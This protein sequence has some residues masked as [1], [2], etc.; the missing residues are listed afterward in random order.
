VAVA[1]QR[2]QRRRPP[3][4]PGYPAQV[5]IAPRTLLTFILLSATVLAVGGLAYVF[6]TILVQ[7]LVATVLAM[8]LEPLVQV[9]ERRGIRRGGAIAI[10]FALVAVAL[11]GFAYLV[12]EPLVAELNRFANDLPD[13]L[14]ELTHGRG[15]LGFLETRYHV[16]EEAR[17]AVKQH[18]AEGATGT[19]S[20]VTQ[21]VSTGGAILFVA[22][23]TLFVLLGGRQ[24]FDSLVRLVPASQTERVQRTGTGVSR[25]VGGYVSGN[26]L[27]SVIAGS[28]TTIVLLA[29]HVP[30]P[31]PLGLAVAVLDLLPLVGATIGTVLV[32]SV[33]LT[34]GI[35][36][37]AIVV[38]AMLLYQQIENH[39]LQQLV[40]HRTVQLS[41]LAISV[42]VAAGA[43][44][45]GVL[46]AL[47]GIP[48][49]G[50][51]KVVF[52]ELSGWAHERSSTSDA[53][54]DGSPT[55]SS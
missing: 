23:L 33:A 12:F 18:G 26:L 52:G 53:A 43:E 6:R 51:L 3:S 19:L 9:F 55:P 4:L 29:T 30:Y 39:T 34:Q 22:F 11:V 14:R 24:W 36:T 1:P 37:A 13:L 54:A 35:P 25:A 47:L 2:E 10:T 32:G 21:V 5:S 48:I 31:V 40:Y 41:P 28:V 38:G 27:I 49:A 8:A 45:G 16:V 17:A 15:R 44:V 7:L 46:G 50:A 42:S 20:I